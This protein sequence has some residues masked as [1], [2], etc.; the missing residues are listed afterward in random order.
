MDS[1]LKSNC[2]EHSMNEIMMLNTTFL[3]MS[4]F[5]ELPSEG[6]LLD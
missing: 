1:L 3:A 5:R 4:F 6:F 2:S